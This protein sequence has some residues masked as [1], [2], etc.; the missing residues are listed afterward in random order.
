[1]ER[2]KFE[3]RDEARREVFEFIEGRYNPR[4]RHSA[5]GYVSPA[6]FERRQAREETWKY[7]EPVCGL[8]LKSGRMRRL[9]APHGQTDSQTTK[10]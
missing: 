7:R 3:D 1:M 4:R 2:R 8:K 6:E 10:W 9:V 5:L